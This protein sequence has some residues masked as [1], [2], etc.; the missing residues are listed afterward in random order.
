MINS[1]IQEFSCR[2]RVGSTRS[3]KSPRSQLLQGLSSAGAGPS[4]ACASPCYSDASDQA[5]PPGLLRATP[6]RPL[7]SRTPS[8]ARNA[9]VGAQIDGVDFGNP[10]IMQRQQWA[11]D[12]AQWT[13][14][15]CL[16]VPKVPAPTRRTPTTAQG[17]GKATPP[18]S[19]RS[20][21][22]MRFACSEVNE[23][24]GCMC[25]R[26]LGMDGSRRVST[27]GNAMR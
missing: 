1:S 19:R 11:M 14:P 22:S 20:T 25:M 24:V 9:I 13:S 2:G 27:G 16:L 23:A 5:L 17:R 4:Q 8:P 15:A 10:F 6:P 18:S 26:A 3:S 7:F 21:R 12:M